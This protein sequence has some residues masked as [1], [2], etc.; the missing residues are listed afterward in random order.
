MEVSFC[1]I[2][3]FKGP[4]S[5]YRQALLDFSR[6]FDVSHFDNVVMAFY[7]GSGPEVNKAASSTRFFFNLI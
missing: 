5:S 3:S 6:D 1:S 2:V 7:T 4:Y